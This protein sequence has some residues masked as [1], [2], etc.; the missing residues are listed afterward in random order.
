MQ[1]KETYTRGLLK[2]GDKCE[3]G[4]KAASHFRVSYIEH[5][6]DNGLCV[7][8]RDDYGYDQC[9]TSK[10]DGYEDEACI[11]EQR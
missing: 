5:P 4:R 8:V 9:R 6:F 1:D 11:T 3:R 10:Y 7:E 2:K